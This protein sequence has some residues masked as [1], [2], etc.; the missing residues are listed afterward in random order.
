MRFFVAS[1]LAV[2]APLALAAAD[3]LEYKNT[4]A[5]Q[6]IKE[7]VKL[8]ILPIGDS[9]TVGYQSSD[10]NGYRQRLQENLSKNEVV[11]AGT[12]H[13]GSMN[14][15]YHAAWSGR[16]IKYISDSVPQSLKQRPNVVLLHAGTNDMNLNELISF[17]G[18]DPAGAA[19]RLGALIDKIIAACPDA[20]V[21]VA[22]IINT[23][24]PGQQPGTEVFQ[25]LIPEVVQKRRDDGHHVLAVDFA[26]AGDDILS[27][28]CIHPD[29]DGYHKMGD[30]WYDFI[31]QIPKDWINQPVGDDPKRSALPSSKAVPGDDS[32]SGTSD[33]F[34]ANLALLFV[35]QAL[36]SLIFNW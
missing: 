36:L 33:M 34:K 31:T 12:E 20:A 16:T 18:N 28:D 32:G 14:D 11:F 4:A 13:S 27:K 22:Q 10:K 26:A 29:D 3:A 19:L 15:P 24:D 1:A 8:R 30:Y 23:C 35:A 9:I 5:G 6:V 7:G 2:F 17:E 21:L 25:K